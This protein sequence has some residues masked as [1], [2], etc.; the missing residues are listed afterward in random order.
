MIGRALDTYLPALI[1]PIPSEITE[2][3]KLPD[4]A[5]AL[6]NVHS[7]SKECFFD[8]LN[9]FNT[10]FHKRLIFDRFFLVMLI[11]AYRKISRE[12][13]SA[14]ILSVSSSLLK[15]LEKCFPF[16]LTNDQKGA[17][18]DI[19]KDL[20]GKVNY[21]ENRSRNHFNELMRNEYIGK[22]PLYD[23]AKIEATYPDGKVLSYSRHGKIQYALIPTYTND[24]ERL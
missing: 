24:G 4:L 1:D 23:L 8:H 5:S 9:A 3:L 13:R 20:I 2:S 18:E 10:P 21:Y 17:V 12:R 16:R 14:A 7:P 6:Q 11:I 19:V 15:N 22:E